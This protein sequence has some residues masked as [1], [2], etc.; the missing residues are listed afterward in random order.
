MSGRAT[1]QGAS[2]GRSLEDARVL[3]SKTEGPLGFPENAGAGKVGVGDKMR[4]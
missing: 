4:E 2:L 3:Q 1:V